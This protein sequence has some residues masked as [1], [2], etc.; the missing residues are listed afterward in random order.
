MSR[1]SRH[2]LGVHLG[3]RVIHRRRSLAIQSLW[4]LFGRR[5]VVLVSPSQERLLNRNLPVGRKRQEKR[6]F[7]AAGAATMVGSKQEEE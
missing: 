3:V 7:V 4:R 6:R 5:L 2:V 1:C